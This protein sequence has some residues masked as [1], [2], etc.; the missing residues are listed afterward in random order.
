MIVSIASQKGGTGKTTTSLSLAAGLAQK[1]KKVL[2]VDIAQD[3]AQLYFEHLQQIAGRRSLPE[4]HPGERGWLKITAGCP[5][6]S[7]HWLLA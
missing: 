6:S 4:H 3:G 1:G 2:L 7:E 5:G